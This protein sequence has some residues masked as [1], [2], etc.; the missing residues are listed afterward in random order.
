MVK[1]AW[2]ACALVNEAPFLLEWIAHYRAM[3]F[4]GAVIFTDSSEDG[5]DAMA[6]RLAELGHVRHV[7]LSL[8]PGR[9]PVRFGLRELP[10]LLEETGADW[11]LPVGIDEYLEIRTGAGDLQ[12]LLEA[13]GPVDAVSFARRPF[14]SSGQRGLPEGAIRE[15]YR[16]AAPEAEQGPMM[17][18]ALKTLFRPA[19]VAR[20]AT[21]RPY[22]HSPAAE[23]RWV[24]AGGAPMPAAYYEGQWAAHEA[25][26]HRLA[27]L[28]HFAVP[29]P[30]VFIRRRGIPEDK[31]QRE[32]LTED[33][34][35]LDINAETAMGMA[36]AIALSAPLLDALRAD[37]QLA[38]LEA[39]GRDWHE[40]AMSELLQ[41]GKIAGLCTEMTN[42]HREASPAA[43]RSSPRK[44][45]GLY[46]PPPVRPVRFEVAPSPDGECRAVLHGGFHKTATT[47]L[48]KRLEDNEAWLG[49]QSVYVVHHQKLRKH[50]TFPSQLDAYRALKLPRRTR[51]TE[52]ELQGFSDAFFAEPLALRPARMILSDENIPGLPAH[53]VTS[54][55][56]YEYRKVFF[57]RFARR[58]PLP[59]SD[60]F[61]AVRDYADFFASSYVE[62]LRSA[63]PTTSGRVIT[64]EEMR[65][66]VLASL[67]SWRQVLADFA[68]VF[69]ETRI[70]VWRFEE[71]R[72][73]APRILQLF[74][75]EGVNTN[76]LQVKEEDSRTRPTASA[77]AVEKLV[78]I[79]EMDGAAA[80]ARQSKEVQEAFPLGDENGKFDPWSAQERAH[81][82][83]L[84]DKDWQAIRDDERLCVLEP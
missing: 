10:P 25:F 13:L 47:Y 39:A 76:R 45:G 3:G 63:T 42:I 50:I 67:P 4:G 8:K 59:V 73:L 23:A 41:D 34:R 24:D 72:A 58:I 38:E 54:G 29:S 12:S 62:Y 52:A 49:K 81:L 71:F 75:G 17:T 27:R 77:Q 32:A 14:G 66:N 46:T 48:Q 37:P 57:E 35:K 56:L 79:S 69:P 31:T 44:G 55:K 18:R 33:W 20:I 68:E 26:S 9:D 70:H 5:T 11:A 1:N 21:H 28:N 53:C 2:I 36:G 74:C 82:G 80:M 60:A 22:F 16:Q 51:F 19:R 64:P 15:D 43:A 30:E 40:A 61:F 7:P 83:T 84:Y 65:R 78:L 6:A